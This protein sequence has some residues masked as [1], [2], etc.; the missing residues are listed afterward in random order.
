M[1]GYY[2]SGDGVIVNFAPNKSFYLNLGA[3]DGS[4]A[5]GIQSGI[6]P[7]QFNGYWF[8]IGEIGRNWVLGEGII[9]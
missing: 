1:P 6:T 9:L 7:P 3:Y 5:R 2:N 8:T 4:N